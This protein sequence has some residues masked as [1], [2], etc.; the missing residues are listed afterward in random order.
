MTAGGHSP[1]GYWGVITMFRLRSSHHVQYLRRSTYGTQNGWRAFISVLNNVQVLYTEITTSASTWTPMTY[2]PITGADVGRVHVYA[3]RVVQVPGVVETYFDGAL[4]GTTSIS[5][6]AA[7]SFALV[8]ILQSDGCDILA[9]GSFTCNSATSPSQAQLI[10]YMLSARAAQDLPYSMPG[11]G[12]NILF[13]RWSAKEMRGWALADNGAA[14][15]PQLYNMYDGNTAGH[16]RNMYMTG[17]VTWRE[18]RVNEGAKAYGIGGATVAGSHYRTANGGGFGAVSAPWMFTL[19]MRVEAAITPAGATHIIL[20]RGNNTNGGWFFGMGPT[21]FLLRTFTGTTNYDVV[22]NVP[23]WDIGRDLYVTCECAGG[24]LR[25]W[26]DGA[27]VAQFTLPQPMTVHPGP[28]VL[29]NLETAAFFHTHVAVFGITGKNAATSAAEIL[30]NVNQS[31]TVGRLLPIAGATHHYD[32]TK[33]I[34]A[35]GGPDIANTPTT[36]AQ[37]V[38]SGPVEPFTL[39]AGGGFVVARKTERAYAWESTPVSGGFTPNAAG[40]YYDSSNVGHDGGAANG[41]SVALLFRIDTQAVNKSRELMSIG[42]AGQRMSIRMNGLNNALASQWF[43]GSAWANSTNVVIGGGDLGR[44][45]LYISQFDKNTGRVRSFWKRVE[46]GAPG[47]T[48]ATWAPA[49][50]QFV[51]LGHLQENVAY[52]AYFAEENTIFACATFDGVWNISEIGALFDGVA[53]EDDIVKLPGR[54]DHLWSFKQAIGSGS[55]LPATVPDSIGSSPL[56]MVGAPTY[57]PHYTHGP[58]WG[59]L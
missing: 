42:A 43:T 35:A 31:R 4:V 46:Q 25:I 49:T 22:Y 14:A 12:S 27:S 5:A 45:H 50:S 16:A 59:S 21:Y 48:A 54:M 57:K 56:T 24:V 28:M 33:D 19:H 52:P 29:A 8:D 13:N 2:V 36:L 3:M 11:A 55:S 40:T 58:K 15:P 26:V 9:A 39:S 1:S 7:G 47:T 34:V 37:R 23:G 17:S 53:A 38:E 32:F 51:R 6:F 44:M 18:A 41:K 10:S 20:S 30:Q